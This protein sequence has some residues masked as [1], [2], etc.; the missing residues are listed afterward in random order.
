MN[1]TPIK[2]YADFILPPSVVTKIDVSRVVSEMEQIDNELTT[3]AVRA[4]IGNNDFAQPTMSPQLTAFLQDN[5]I[6]LEDSHKR[7][8]LIKQMRL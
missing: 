4:K 8:E 1:E 7:S 2:T 5:E 6:T 3:A